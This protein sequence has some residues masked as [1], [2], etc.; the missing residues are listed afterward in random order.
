MKIHIAKSSGFCFGVKRAI[1]MSHD[2]AG[3]NKKVNVFGEIVH[4]N[5]VVRELEKKG[6]KKIKKIY[7]AKDS[8]LIISAH[9]V[10]KKIFEKAKAK[11]HK[12]VDATCPKVIDIYE[13][14]RKLEKNNKIIIIGDSGHD[15]VK[16]IAGQLRTTPIIIDSADNM[17]MKELS[18]VKKA[19]VITQSTQSLENINEIMG[20]L[21][22]ILPDVKL[23]NTT[24]GITVVKQ[25]EIKSLPEE[26]DV[27]LIVG[28]ANSANTKRL[29]KMSKEINKKTH[30]IGSADDLKPSWFKN[31]EKVGIMAGASTPDN[32]T[33]EI[34]KELKR[35]DKIINKNKKQRISTK[36][37][38]TCT[39]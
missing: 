24:C 8:T 16:G 15:E 2:L 9:G 28:S 12:V 10:S 31:I 35:I 20:R 25:R 36:A 7:R 3:S 30:W 5:F 18:R 34:V 11:G 39:C 33:G 14:G 1:D 27:V 21:K 13:I 37:T 19:A 38:N 32:I 22:E 23:Y 6:V 29:Y 4:N 17:P 26:N